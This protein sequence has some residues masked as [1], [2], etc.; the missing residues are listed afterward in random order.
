MLKNPNTDTFEKVKFVPADKN[1]DT[2]G[3]VLFKKEI[4]FFVRKIKIMKKGIEEFNDRF[5][6]CSNDHMVSQ[7][8]KLIE[9]KEEH[10]KMPVRRF[11]S[12]TFST[13]LNDAIFQL[14]KKQMKSKSNSI[15]T[16]QG[17]IRYVA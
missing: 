9:E 12:N 1:D 4:D 10:K 13:L 16:M 11:F 15:M 8:L 14:T 7:M 6:S 17:S 2:Q 3:H 5:D